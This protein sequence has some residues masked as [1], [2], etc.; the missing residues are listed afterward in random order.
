MAQLWIVAGPNGAGKTTLVTRRIS[1]R[2]P[3]VNPDEIAQALPR[4]GDRLDER[5]AGEMALN[6]RNALLAQGADFAIET[7]LTGNSALRFIG[8][9]KEAGYK[10]NLVYVG[11]SSAALSMQ[12]VLDRV[13]RGGHAVPMSAVERRYADTMSK[14]A[15][16]SE[17]VDRCYVLDNSDRR[18]RLLLTVDGRRTKF[19]TRD[20]PQWFVEALAAHTSI[21][22]SDQGEGD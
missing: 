22:R 19:L 9:A 16:V 10:L 12:R 6:Q 18:R 3:I 13:R 5:Q 7:T 4:I 1:M 20:R 15:I 11:L 14:L 2:I 17:M 21:L 8:N